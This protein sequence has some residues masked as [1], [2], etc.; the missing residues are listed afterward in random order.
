MEKSKGKFIVFEGI[1][2]CGKGTQIKILE[3]HLSKDNIDVHLTSEPTKNPIGEMV[4]RDYLSGKVNFDPLVVNML[5]AADRLDH[6]TNYKYGMRNYIDAGVN[7]ICD[8]YYHSS[9]AYDISLDVDAKDII[10]HNRVAISTFRPDLVLFIDIPPQMAMERILSR[11]DKLEKYE[12]VK[13]LGAVRQAYLSILQMEN[14]INKNIVII[15]GDRS[16]EKVYIDVCEEVFKVLGV[17][18]SENN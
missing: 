1:D 14:D 5:F 11:G 6:V 2:G 17:E 13:R 7:V 10:N 15:D 16:V 4:R 12:N 9:I 18:K 3:T 8:R